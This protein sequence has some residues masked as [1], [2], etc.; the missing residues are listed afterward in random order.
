[1]NALRSLKLELKVILTPTADRFLPSGT[2]SHLVEVAT[3]AAPGDGHVNLARWADLVVVLPCTANT[4]ADIAN[5]HAPNLLTTMALAHR[6][7]MLL[8]PVMN[9]EMWDAKPVQRNVR[10]LRG[11][12]HRVVAP[13]CA[14]VY[15]VA[16]GGLVQGIAPPPVDEILNL[17]KQTLRERAGS[18]SASM[19]GG[20]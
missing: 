6:Q 16:S 14:L 5:G 4:L 12:G 20:M 17:I 15:E 10:T 9:T 18:P 13:T 2:V 1:V 8:F 7:P 3:D 19:E 11:D